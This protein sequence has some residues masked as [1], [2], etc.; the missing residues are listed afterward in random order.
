MKR[1]SIL[2]A[3]L[4]LT[5]AGAHGS[6]SHTDGGQSFATLQPPESQSYTLSLAADGYP[7]GVREERRVASAE[8]CLVTRGRWSAHRD[9]R[10]SHTAR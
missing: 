8:R 1:L 5:T 10:E 2:L 6:E 4:V 3:A 7:L 9:R